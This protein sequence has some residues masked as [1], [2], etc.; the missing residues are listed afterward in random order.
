MD[1]GNDK[2]NRN[3]Q[4]EI[5][6]RHDSSLKNVARAFFFFYFLFG[7]YL[8]LTLQKQTQIL[9]SGVCCCCCCCCCLASWSS[10]PPPPRRRISP[11]VLMERRIR[12]EITKPARSFALTAWGAFKEGAGWGG[13][14]CTSESPTNLTDVAQ[15]PRGAEVWRFVPH[16]ETLK[17]LGF[18][19]C[20]QTGAAG[21]Q[22]FPGC[23]KCSYKPTKLGPCFF[24]SC[25]YLKKKHFLC[26]RTLQVS[27][28]AL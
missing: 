2:W 10:P 6:I 15:L 3:A 24:D 22:L 9:P 27:E 7:T 4:I 11:T 19:S 18:F 28:L 1:A 26:K 12:A 14:V 20:Q 8:S 17:K 25:C 16:S 13:S 5:P 23:S 21:L